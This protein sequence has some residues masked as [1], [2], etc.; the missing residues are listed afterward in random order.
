MG[1]RVAL[2]PSPSG[3]VPRRVPVHIPVTPVVPVVV[4]SRKGVLPAGATSRRP[5]VF[6]AA[7][8]A[9]PRPARL[10]MVR[11]AGRVLPTAVL[12]EK[13][14]RTA[15]LADR[16]P[17][18]PVAGL[19][20]T[21][22]GLTRPFQVVAVPRRPAV[23]LVVA[24]VGSREVPAVLGIGTP[25]GVR[26]RPRPNVGPFVIPRGCDD[27]RAQGRVA[28][29]GVT[30]PRPHEAIRLAGHTAR[31]AG[32]VA[33]V[34]R[35][36]QATVGRLPLVTGALAVSGV[37]RPPSRRVGAGPTAT[38]TYIG[39]R[40]A[41]TRAVPVPT[42]RP[43]RPRP[44]PLLGE[45]GLGT[46]HAPTLAPTQTGVLVV[47]GPRPGHVPATGVRPFPHSSLLFV[48]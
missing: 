40:L 47:P 19:A 1:V 9:P 11:V 16:P 43:V 7:G 14:P 44:A 10:A 34:A 22:A 33:V 28:E 5:P 35:V 30:F 18:A 46:L 6:R 41:P 36:V 37:R 45:T 24:L 21:D 25:G 13:G 8:A 31:V 2:V 3:D 29:I 42:R 39:V 17:V 48:F 27:R 20:Q 38:V 23:P 32:P 15:T 12:A 26:T 4:P